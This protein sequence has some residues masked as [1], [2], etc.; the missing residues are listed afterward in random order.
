MKFHVGENGEVQG[1]FEYGKLDISSN[2]EMGFRPV[3]LLIF[4]CRL[5][6]WGAKEGFREETYFV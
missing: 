6:W 5:K 3:Q 1:D 4:T 2:P